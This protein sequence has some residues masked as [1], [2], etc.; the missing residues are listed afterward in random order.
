MCILRR[1]TGHSVNR[2]FYALTSVRP[3]WHNRGMQSTCYTVTFNAETRSHRSYCDVRTEFTSLLRDSMTILSLAAHQ[4][5]PARVDRKVCLITTH[6]TFG[7]VQSDE[8]VLDPDAPRFDG[9]L[10]YYGK[11]GNTPTYVW[12]TGD[13]ENSR[14]W[15]VCRV[16]DD[17]LWA[18]IIVIGWPRLGIRLSGPIT[19]ESVRMAKS[20][21]AL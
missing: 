20:P 4:I 5:A 14:V 10:M 7:L 21:L 2:L 6:R 3:I 15:L 13:T 11:L 18:D 9:D 17:S 16:G 12:N 8:F 19:E 1:F